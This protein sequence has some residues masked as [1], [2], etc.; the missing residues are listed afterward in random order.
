MG[1]TFLLVPI[2]LLV[3]AFMVL[4]NKFR[5]IKNHKKE[6]GKVL[7]QSDLQREEWKKPWAL[8]LRERHQKNPTDLTQQ[9][10]IALAVLEA[11]QSQAY[12]DW[13]FAPSTDT[14][15]K[16]EWIFEEKMENLLVTEWKD[17]SSLKDKWEQDL[18]KWNSVRQMMNAYSSKLQQEQSD[19]MFY[20]L[21]RLFY[22]PQPTVWMER[23]SFVST[24]YKLKQALDTS[25]TPFI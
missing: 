6:L 7:Q 23:Q 8:L 25:D 13:S 22:M 9:A 1:P 3:V 17:E 5:V 15:L 10:I 16:N 2:V 21:E 20:I 14:L 24:Q 11:S 4:A 19:A 12:M 18:V